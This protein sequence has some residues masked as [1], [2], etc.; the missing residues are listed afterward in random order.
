MINHRSIIFK[1]H[2]LFISFLIILTVSFLFVHSIL[3]KAQLMRFV[4]SSLISVHSGFALKN[5]EL[6]KIVS[7]AKLRRLV[8][9]KGEIVLRRRTRKERVFLYKYQRTYY[10]IVKSKRGLIMFENTADN[11][12]LKTATVIF[13]FVFLLFLA[14]YLAV[15]RSIYPLKRF[16]KSVSEFARGNL[17]VS[18]NFKSN[19]EV[20][21]IAR[22]F[23]TA[24]KRLKDS[25]KMREM[26]LRNIAHELKTPITKGNLSVEFVE[27]KRTREILR[28]LFS[29]MNSLTDEL[30]SAEK[31]SEATFNIQ[32]ISIDDAVKKAKDMLFAD[33][34]SIECS[35]PSIKI[36]VDVASFSIALKNLIDNAIKFSSDNKATIRLEQNIL[37]IENKGEKINASI[38]HLFEPFF[39]ETS[40]R[41]KNG[42]GLGLYITKHILDRHRIGIQYEYRNG[43]NIFLLDLSGV[44]DKSS[45]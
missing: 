21:E 19:D 6:S 43:T 45:Q 25:K 8:L 2:L 12:A 33:E 23:N 18:F 20:G 16:S 26:F 9:K 35:M 4:R 10:L 15:L 17:D 24:I 39:K 1:V 28:N 37:T 41:N 13:I 3:Q 30:L 32:S 5:P 38:E 11:T 42:M 31:F 44:I 27:D 7:D 14:L 34:K 29:R 22:Q 36:N 40:R